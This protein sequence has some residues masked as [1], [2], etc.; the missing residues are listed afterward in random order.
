MDQA[1]KASAF[2]VIFMYRLKVKSQ[3]QMEYRLKMTDTLLFLLYFTLNYKD[4]FLKKKGKRPSYSKSL[5]NL[6]TN[7]AL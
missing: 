3:L 5:L 6:G 4:K 2:L 7:I 1:L